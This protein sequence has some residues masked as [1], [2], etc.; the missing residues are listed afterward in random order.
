MMLF[1]VC[2]DL[3]YAFVTSYVVEAF[4]TV[5]C[6]YFIGIEKV[7]FHS[8]SI[9]YDIGYDIEDITGCYKKA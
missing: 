6:V 8:L 1:T 7:F 3:H 5:C 4:I 9:G 2:C